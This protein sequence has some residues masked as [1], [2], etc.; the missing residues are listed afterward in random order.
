MGPEL[1]GVSG[2]VSFEKVSK[3][4]NKLCLCKFSKLAHVP[5]GPQITFSLHLH[6]HKIG[7]PFYSSCQGPGMAGNMV[8]P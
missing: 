3:H 2:S 7:E 5:L 4:D 6:G 1:T 8:G